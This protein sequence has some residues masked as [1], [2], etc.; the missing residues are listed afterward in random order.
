MTDPITAISALRRPRLLIRAARFGQSDYRRE[1]D[2]RR[3]IGRQV[4]P[5]D[6]VSLLLSA[7]GRMEENRRK[8]EVTYSAAQ[9]IEVLIALVAEGRLARRHP[10]E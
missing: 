3:L 8:G 6:A 10:A 9:H 2:L 7:E 4:L 1:R 5:E